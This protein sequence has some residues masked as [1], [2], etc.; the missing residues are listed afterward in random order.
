MDRHHVRNSHRKAPKSDNVYLK[1]LVKLY[2]FLARM[3]STDLRSWP[4]HSPRLQDSDKV[5]HMML[6]LRRPYRLRFQQSRP[7]PP[8]HVAHKPPSHVYLPCG[9][10]RREPSRREGTL[11]QDYRRGRYY[12]RRQPSSHCSKAVNCGTEIYR[13]SQGED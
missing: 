3:S 11:W 5:T 1:L 4:P 2:R 7:P 12:H 10:P 6:I 9:L 8:L 13:H